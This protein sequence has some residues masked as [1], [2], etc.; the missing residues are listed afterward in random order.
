MAI[1]RRARDDAA[2][3]GAP[4]LGRL[5]ITTCCPHASVSLGPIMRASMSLALPAVNGTI[6]RIGRDG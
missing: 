6:T 4:A 2:G 1:G 3:D 5:S